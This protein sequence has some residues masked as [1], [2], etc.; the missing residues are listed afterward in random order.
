MPRHRRIISKEESVFAAGLGIKPQPTERRPARKSQAR[1]RIEIEAVRELKETEDSVISGTDMS[2]FAPSFVHKRIIGG[3]KGL[4]SG[5]VTGGIGG[6]L[7]GGGDNSRERKARRAVENQRFQTFGEGPRTAGPA[8]SFGISDP[9]P[10][11][12]MSVDPKT[13]KCVFKLGAVV[14]PDQVPAATGT[15]MVV[16]E[17]AVTGAFGMPA[18]RPVNIPQNHLTCPPGMVLGEDSLCYPKAVLRRDSRFR[19]WRP[20]TRPV[21]T[22]GEV[23]AIAKGRAAI[24]RGRDRMAGLGVTVK[25]K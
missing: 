12:G 18:I 19:K 13:G 14:G 7:S 17:D 4:A 21:L 22:G 9:C 3:I 16:F 15:S 11:P 20:G 8:R 23:R 1:R 5:G 6:F 24:I 2:G 10:I 25:K